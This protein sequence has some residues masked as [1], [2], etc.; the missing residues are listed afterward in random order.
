MFKEKL[1]DKE[2]Y[3]YEVQ[4]LS[5][6]ELGACNNPAGNNSTYSRTPVSRTPAVLSRKVS[7][8]T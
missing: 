4:D 5:R 1:V 7:L 6:K 8:K 2:V 3:I